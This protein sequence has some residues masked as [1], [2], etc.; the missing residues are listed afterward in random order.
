MPNLIDCLGKRFG[1]LLVVGRSN[2]RWDCVCD[3]GNTTSVP[4]CNLLSGNSRSCGCATRE[5]L[6]ARNIRHGRARRG[7][8]TPEYRAWKNIIARTTARNNPAWPKYGGRG[9]G[10]A[11]EWRHDFQAF[12]DHIGPR[13][14]SDYSVDRIDND[15]GYEPGNVRWASRTVQNRNTSQNKRYELDGKMYCLVELAEISGLRRETIARRI[16][17]GWPM[18]DVVG[19]AVLGQR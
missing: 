3:C 13:P 17:V 14:G 15:R 10:I 5:A 2:R 9:I 8:S 1:R 18:K 12:L 16:R 7:H 6:D 4:G 19:L 11:P